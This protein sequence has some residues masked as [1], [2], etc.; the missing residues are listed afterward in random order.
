M[1]DR[2]QP[3]PAK[4][5][6]V[7]AF[8]A[9]YIIWGSTYLAIRVAVE[10]I[11]PFL[12]AGVRYMIAGGI[13]YAWL[14]WRGVAAPARIHW[15]SAAVVGGLMLLGGNG[16]VVW[17]EQPGKVPSSIAALMVS[18]VPL[19]MVLINWARPRGVRPT[20]IEALGL[21]LGFVGVV[22]LVAPG[23]MSGSEPIDRGGAIALILAPIFWATGSIYSRHAKLPESV[24]LATGMQMLAGGAL[25]VLAGSV[26]GEWGRVN[27]EAISTKSVLAFGYLVVFGALIGFTAYIWIL[28]VS[29][30]AK[31]GTYAYVNP[32]IAVFLGWVLLSEPITSSMLV[33]MAVILT[34]VILITTRAT[35]KSERDSSP[36]SKPP[37]QGRAVLD[38]T[39]E[40]SDA[41]CSPPEESNAP[42]SAQLSPAICKD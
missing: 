36:E 41:A 17:A 38:E 18:A 35:S 8:A 6:V 13:L 25:L 33:A 12:M 39:A 20:S 32:A 37:V 40:N 23:S 24:F 5:M 19:W 3:S 27:V 42:S 7:V 22:I 31:V 26:T 10:T 9:V 30:P 15:R 2:S 28:R 14:R 34:G 29:T 21:I 16:G 11:P 1:L 4:I